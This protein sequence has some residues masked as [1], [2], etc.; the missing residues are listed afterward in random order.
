MDRATTSSP[1][2]SDAAAAEGA[3]RASRLALSSP[4]FEDGQPIPR[5]HALEPDGQN[6]PPRLV[7]TG[8]PAGTKEFALIVDD[9]DAPRKTPW[10]HWVAWGVPREAKALPADG[11]GLSQGTNDF[12]ATGWGGPRPPEGDPAH[13]Y[14]FRL[15]A[16]D[17]SPKAKPGATKD[18]LLAA[19]KGH[20][21]AEAE[22]V[23]T[24]RR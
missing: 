21:L 14:R 1:S 4:D 20:V 24:Y 13:R 8:A 12:G 17:A 10:V 7:W 3:Q 9:P 22:L 11:D 15:Y 16:L 5:R 23:G 18:D 2:R 6:V 19:T